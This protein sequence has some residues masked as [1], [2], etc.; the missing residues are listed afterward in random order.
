MFLGVSSGLVR[1]QLVSGVRHYSLQKVLGPAKP[2]WFLKG[3]GFVM[4]PGH[5]YQVV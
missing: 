2:L 3:N 1:S 4:E 5:F